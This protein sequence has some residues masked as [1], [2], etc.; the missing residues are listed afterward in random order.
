M[1]RLKYIRYTKNIIGITSG[2][3][4]ISGLN[5]Y[6]KIEILVKSK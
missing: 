6:N 3:S 1:D 2:I 4:I 5:Y